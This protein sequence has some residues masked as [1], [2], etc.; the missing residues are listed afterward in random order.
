[1]VPL[2]VVAANAIAVPISVAV[3]DSFAVAVAAAV[4]IAHCRCHCRQPLLLRSPSTIA[5]TI[6]VA[7]PS[8]IAVAIALAIGHCHLH[9]CQPL[10][11]PS[12]SA[13]TVAMP[14]AIYE[15]C[16]LGVAKIVFSQLKQRV[17]TI[18]YFVQTVGGALIKAGWL[19][20]CQA[21]M[22]NTSVGRQAVS[23][24]RI[25]RELA[26]SRGAAGGQKGGDID[27]PW[28]VLF[29]WLLEYQP[30]TDSI[31]DDILDVVEGIASETVIELMQE[32][33]NMRERYD[34]DKK[35]YT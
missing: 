30:L 11:L 3:A 22:A 7:L 9:H 32:E 12:L 18:F 23:I 26:R 13:I 4:T 27:W 24:E 19:T 1:M 29:C 16:C 33:N 8:A 5:A 10:Q 25:V 2:T 14:L 31:C 17:F 35:M 6:S 20:R 15:S 21:A 28:E 34:S